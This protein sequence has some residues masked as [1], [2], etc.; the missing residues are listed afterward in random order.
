M[1]LQAIRGT[2]GRRERHQRGTVARPKRVRATHLDPAAQDHRARH[3]GHLPHPLL[4]RHPTITAARLHDKVEALLADL[5]Q[6]V[7]PMG[8]PGRTGRDLCQQW[9]RDQWLIRTTND[10][11]TEVY[12]L[13]SHTQQALRLVEW[14]APRP[15]PHLTPAETELYAKLTSH[16]WTR[17]RRVEQ[18]RIPLRVALRAFRALAVDLA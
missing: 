17:F 1:G 14:A 6:T 7:D 12:T 3:R 13:T 2:E 15:V 18:E 8:I 5:R 9:M 11:G 10:D 16:E 4:P